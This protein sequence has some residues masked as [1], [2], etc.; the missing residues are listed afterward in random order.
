MKRITS[1]FL[2]FFALLYGHLSI[3]Q[4]PDRRI[5]WHNDFSVPFLLSSPAYKSVFKGVYDLRSQLHFSSKK[6]YTLGAG[7]SYFLAKNGYNRYVLNPDLILQQRNLAPE[8]HIG[9]RKFNGENLSTGFTLFYAAV[10]NRY[11]FNLADTLQNPLN[12]FHSAVGVN[13]YLTIYNGENLSFGFNLGYRV[14]IYRFNPEDY[15]YQTLM[16]SFDKNWVRNYS[17]ILFI[18]VGFALHQ[19]PFA[20]P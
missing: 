1:V 17:G 15:G 20:T 8:V 19:W 4:V 6:G 7:L 11:S 10:F 18:G 12:F 2:L 3:S 5:H 16:V 14:N 9:F 13:T